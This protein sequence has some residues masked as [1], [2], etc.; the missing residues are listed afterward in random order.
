MRRI[1]L[2]LGIF[3]ISVCQV[4]AQTGGSHRRSTVPKNNV[5]FPE[6]PRV[7]AFEAYKKYNAGK[8]II[9]QCGGESFKKRHIIGALNIPSRAVR[10]EKMK[11]PNFPRKGIEIFTYCY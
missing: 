8:A 7:S 11:L 5:D 4:H 3:V 1:I 9:M 6:V 10:H 2:I